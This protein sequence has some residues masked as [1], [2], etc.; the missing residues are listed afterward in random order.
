LIL[1]V[2]DDRY[3]FAVM[4]GVLTGEC[5]TRYA[6]DGPQAQVDEVAALKAPS[7]RDVLAKPF[8]SMTLSQHVAAVW[9]RP[10]PSSPG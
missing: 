6:P 1:I 4:N 2:D 10:T 5:E 9:A 3:M 8:D 7:A